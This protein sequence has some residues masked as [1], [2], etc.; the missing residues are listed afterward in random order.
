MNFKNYVVQFLASIEYLPNIQK[1]MTTTISKKFEVKEPIEKVWTY[2]T[3]PEKIVVCVPGASLTEKI[4]DRNYKG[5]VTL[6]FGPVKASYAGEIGFEEID[7]TNY[8]MTLKGKGLDS[9]GKGSADMLMKSSL[10]AIDGGTEVDC[11]MQISIVGKLAQFGARLINDVS[12]QLFNQFINNFKAKLAADSATEIAATNPT[13]AAESMVDAVVEE[14]T[15]AE[16][17]AAVSES[18][19][20]VQKAVADVKKA[21]EALSTDMKEMGGTARTATSNGVAEVKKAAEKV[22]PPKPI[23]PQVDNSLNAFSLMM[24]VVKG[25]FSRLFGGK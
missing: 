21:Q 25:W 15:T 11:S 23:T 10:V 18:A 12:D 19:E 2:L 14:P 13:A 22:I 24:A 1:N 4:D 6:K 16:K 3:D 9:K 7:E 5:G 20:A 8:K 17:A